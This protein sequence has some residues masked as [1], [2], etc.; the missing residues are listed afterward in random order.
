M[1]RS[2]RPLQPENE[3]VAVEAHHRLTVEFSRQRLFDEAGAKA[4]TAWRDDRRA[5][6]FAPGEAENGRIRGALSL[7]QNVNPATGAGKAPYLAASVASSCRASERAKAC[8]ADIG[9]SGPVI[10]NRSFSD[11]NGAKALS[12]TLEIDVL[13]Q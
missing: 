6:L 4:A 3:T 5:A 11:R 9:Y 10:W 13:S 7:P 2:Q 8:L 12:T 1:P